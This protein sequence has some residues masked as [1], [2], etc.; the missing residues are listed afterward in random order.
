[1]KIENI[2][3]E[4]TGSSLCSNLVDLIG[5]LSHNRFVLY[6]SVLTPGMRLL[7]FHLEYNILLD[8]RT[9]WKSIFAG[10]V[11]KDF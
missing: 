10:N 6:L 9:T 8:K 1:M 5:H 11:V 4:N 7:V 3:N 2:L